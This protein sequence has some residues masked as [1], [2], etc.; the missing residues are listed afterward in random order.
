MFL[1]KSEGHGIKA[2]FHLAEEGTG[3]LHLQAVLLT[4]VPLVNCGPQ[5]CI[6]G[7]KAEDGGT[8]TTCLHCGVDEREQNQ[9]EN[10]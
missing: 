5:T 3:G 10:R 8:F 7:L 9:C 4:G 6:S 1:P 2:S